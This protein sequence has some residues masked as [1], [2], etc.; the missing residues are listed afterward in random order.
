MLRSFA[1]EIL[2]TNPGSTC[3]VSMH[4]LK[5][6]GIYICLDAYKR[7]Y[8][9]GCRQLLGLDGHSLKGTFGG[10]TLVVVALDAN[11]CI[12][13]VVYAIVESKN[14]TTWRW[15]MQH[16]GEDLKI[17]NSNNWTFMI[18]R[19]K[20]LQNV[21]DDLYVEVEHCFYVRYMYNNFFRTD[22][23]ILTLKDYLWRAARLIG[24]FEWVKL[25]KRAKQHILG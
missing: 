11:D 5:F 25:R 6:Q 23:K 2:I 22:F 20:G 21:I 7:G 1:A 15:F 14:A 18:D 4:E 13:L 24:I 10:Q 17:L 3:I 8:L 19:Q 16:L 9:T 12:Y